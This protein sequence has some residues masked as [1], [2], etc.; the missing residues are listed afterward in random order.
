ME[1]PLL[2]ICDLTI[3][4]ILFYLLYIL[5]LVP[6]FRMWFIYYCA[7]SLVLVVVYTFLG[8]ASGVGCTC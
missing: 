5:E 6:G 7:S 2:Y 1:L 8:D 4:M 3:I